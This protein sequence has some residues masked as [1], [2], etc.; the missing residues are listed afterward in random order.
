MTSDVTDNRCKCGHA[1]MP[2]MDRCLNCVECG[3]NAPAAKEPGVRRYSVLLSGKGGY[4][5]A[6]LSYEH[7]AA[8]AALKAE[9]SKL[10]AQVIA[11]VW[12][13]PDEVLCGELRE[14]AGRY[15]KLTAENAAMRE[16]LVQVK[17]IN[18]RGHRE[19]LIDAL[20]ASKAG[21][22]QT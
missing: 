22:K 15:E 11:A 4:Q 3:R 7:D 6:V 20:L 21:E 9:V 16:L 1:K 12:M 17:R 5:Q 10:K 13:I 19:G 2:F 18:D 14:H 8:I